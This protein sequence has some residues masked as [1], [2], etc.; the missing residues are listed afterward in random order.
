AAACPFPKMALW[1]RAL[2][3]TNRWELLLE[4]DPGSDKRIAMAW[5]EW[6][7]DE[8]RGANIS[9]AGERNLAGYPHALRTYYSLVDSVYW[10]GFGYKVGLE[11]AGRHLSL[12]AME[13]DYHGDAVDPRSASVFGS[14]MCGDMLI[15]TL[16]GR[17]GWLNLHTHEIRLIGTIAD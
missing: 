8:V 5:F 2:V 11:G 1:L 4:R 15:F 7:S 9:P 3:Q 10:I 16:D 6:Q 14:S 17:G 12:A 13:L